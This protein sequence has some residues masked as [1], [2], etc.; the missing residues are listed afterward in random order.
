MN[1][2][3]QDAHEALLAHEARQRR[4]AAGYGPQPARPMGP[5][6]SPVLTERQKA[7]QEQYIKD[8]NL[9]F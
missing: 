3:E 2:F 7:E 6:W 5:V 1:R 8:H 9:P 4:H